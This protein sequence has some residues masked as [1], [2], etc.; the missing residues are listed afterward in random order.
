MARGRDT[1]EVNIIFH[2]Q[3]IDIDIPGKQRLQM[4]TTTSSGTTH[5]FSDTGGKRIPQREYV[6]PW[7]Q[8]A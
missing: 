1:V 3:Q 6:S 8:K 2:S 7:Q 4:R 5:S